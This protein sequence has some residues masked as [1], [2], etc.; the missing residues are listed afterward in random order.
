MPQTTAQ[1]HN[2]G[3]KP[4]HGSV[5]PNRRLTPVQEESFKQWILSMDQRGIPPRVTTVR[6]MAGL[7]IS[8][9]EK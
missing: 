9:H 6:Q 3:I 7:L 4:R 5:A 8:Q 2:K 1:Q